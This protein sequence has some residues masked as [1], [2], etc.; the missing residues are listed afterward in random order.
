MA[1]IFCQCCVKLLVSGI[2]PCSWHRCSVV[3]GRKRNESNLTF[4]EHRSYF[5]VL[6][7]K[8]ESVTRHLFSIFPLGNNE[9]ANFILSPYCRVL[10]ITEL[11]IFTPIL[12]LSVSFLGSCPS[13]ILFIV[14]SEGSFGNHQPHFVR[15]ARKFQRYWQW[16]L[17]IR[18]RC[19]EN[20]NVCLISI[21]FFGC[22][23][24]L[25][26]LRGVLE[27]KNLIIV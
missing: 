8:I 3:P 1:D 9:T 27:R 21:F 18:Y 16:P 10:E 14:L 7:L 24:S 5:S 25:I 13:Q 20:E 6:K 15:P 23:R 19:S 12:I 22:T 11:Y 2:D 17:P 26:Y 4:W